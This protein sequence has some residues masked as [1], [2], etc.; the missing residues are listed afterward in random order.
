MAR[1]IFAYKALPALPRHFG[2]RFA[3]YV[4]L[5]I[6]VW[7]LPPWGPLVAFA[8]TFVLGILVKVNWARWLAGLSWFWLIVLAPIVFY[9][10]AAIPAGH[11]ESSELFAAIHRSAA[12]VLLLAASHWL[13]RTT[14]VFE[15][16]AAIALVF[17]PLGRKTADMLSLIASLALAFVPW[18]LDEAQAVRDASALRGLSLKRRPVSGLFAMTI[19]LM[20]RVVEKARRTAEALTLRS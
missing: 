1:L 15:I 10:A 8:G 3:I 19:P 20:L 14:T 4:V 13:T 11:L 9:L 2:L 12:M 16:R 5:C 7:L 6:A 18:I 17:R